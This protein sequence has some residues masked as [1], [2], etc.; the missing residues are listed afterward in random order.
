MPTSSTASNQKTWSELSVEQQA[1]LRMAHA[2]G[3]T[4]QYWTDEIWFDDGCF[5]P[6]HWSFL[7]YRIKP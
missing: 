6:Q 3:H 5:E 7:I 4:I 1:A 2:M